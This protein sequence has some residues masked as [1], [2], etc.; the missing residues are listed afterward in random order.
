[1]TC[2][3]VFIL[4]LNFN[5]RTHV[6][7][8][9]SDQPLPARSSPFQSTHPRGVRLRIAQGSICARDFNP[10]THVGCDMRRRSSTR[11]RR[12]F[13]PR[14][15]VGC[16]PPGSRRRWPRPDFNPRTH[17]GCDLGRRAADCRVAI[18]IHA[19]TWG[20]TDQA[21]LQQCLSNISI[22]APTWGATVKSRHAVR[23]VLISIHAPT[24]GAT[25][26]G[27]PARIMPSHFNPRTHVGCDING[28]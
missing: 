23:Q 5:P 1:M 28:R 21:P 11:R 4:L 16:D 6:G 25:F 20:A 26:F 17:V 14:T 24:W 8:D 13:N 18:S 22:H 12:Y 27:S 2:H 19:P 10:R 3:L 9:L 15:H 7:C